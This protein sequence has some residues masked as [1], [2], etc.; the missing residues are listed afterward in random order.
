MAACRDADVG[1][2]P[3]RLCPRSSQ[4]QVNK[5]EVSTAKRAEE[6]SDSITVL[7]IVTV[8]A[9]C[10][11]RGASA[12]LVL[13]RAA[14]KAEVVDG[15]PLIPT[16]G[17]QRDECQKFANHLKRPVPC[18]GLLPDPIPDTSASATEQCIGQVGAFSETVC[19]P[20]AIEWL[21]I[22]SN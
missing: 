4:R 22:H 17:S 21:G 3:V 6:L 19:G 12:T 1:T 14:S 16:T 15:V 2:A 11:S 8:M 9:I 7:S 13:D 18:P 10:T 20:A 5:R